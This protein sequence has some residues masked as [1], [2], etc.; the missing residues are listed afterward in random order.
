MCKN[1]PVA[2]N[3]LS[4]GLP[5]VNKVNLTLLPSFVDQ[6]NV[7]SLN[8][9][10]NCQNFTSSNFPTQKLISCSFLQLF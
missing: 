7:K 5:K 4:I 2:R 6:T 10:K 8:N 1:H 3:K 9:V